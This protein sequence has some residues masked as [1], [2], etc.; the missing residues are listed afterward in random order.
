[1]AAKDLALL[2]VRLFLEQTRAGYPIQ[3]QATEELGAPPIKGRQRCGDKV[4]LRQK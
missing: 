1:M 2:D 3:P 4:A